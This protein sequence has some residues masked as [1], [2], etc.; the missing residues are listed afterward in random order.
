MAS[1]A[2]LVQLRAANKNITTLVHRDLARFWGTLDLAK[3]QAARDA[4][5]EF[6]PGLVS[7]YGDI[8]ATVSADFYDS[9]RLSDGIRGKF[10]A[11]MA[12]G[13][14]DEQVTQ[15]VRYGAGHLFTDTPD[16]MAEFLDGSVSRLVMQAGRDTISRSSIADPRAR[17]WQ[18]VGS[19]T[20]CE[21]C[22]M[23]IDR[24]AV[25][26]E[27][28]ASFETHDHCNCSAEPIWG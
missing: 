17:G 24:G 11:I 3:P 26:S 6:V 8:A 25:Y 27:A 2:E 22:S 5:L 18:R 1:R 16:K 12:S 15:S 21:F 7:Q 9:L 14:T 20:S 10:S 28:T 19:G 13:A 4:L 23:L